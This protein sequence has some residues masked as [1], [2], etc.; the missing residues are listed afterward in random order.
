MPD[1][2]PKRALENK[3]DNREENINLC[4]FFPFVAMMQ[5]S[6]PGQLNHLGAFGRSGLNR[7]LKGSVLPESILGSIVMIIVE[8]RR[9]NPFQAKKVF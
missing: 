6:N 5:A 7:A 9:Q 4:S 2:Y 8:M 3:Q 1:R